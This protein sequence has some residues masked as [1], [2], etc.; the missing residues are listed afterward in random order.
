MTTVPHTNGTPGGANPLLE[1][2][3]RAR[4]IRQLI[5]QIAARM[6]LFRGTLRAQRRDLGELTKL[7]GVDGINTFVYMDALATD[8]DALLYWCSGGEHDRHATNQQ[9]AADVK[10]HPGGS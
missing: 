8:I 7:T 4:R 2:R 10:N 9:L 3:D 1:A 6:P 5:N